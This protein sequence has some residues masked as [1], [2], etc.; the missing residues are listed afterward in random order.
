MALGYLGRNKESLQAYETAI[1]IAEKEARSNPG[2]AS[3]QDN[4]ARVHYMRGEAMH[5]QTGKL[6]EALS[7]YATAIEIEQKAIDANPAVSRYKDWQA[8]FILCRGHVLAQLGKSKEAL[9]A[10][11]EATKIQQHILCEPI[12]DICCVPALSQF[13]FT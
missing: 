5:Q 9:Q 2:N 3:L 1:E 4:L 12:R 13:P 11:Q 8:A 10:Y 6:K 7:E